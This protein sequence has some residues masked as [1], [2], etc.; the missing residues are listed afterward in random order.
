MTD[1]HSDLITEILLLIQAVDAAFETG[2]LALAED[3]DAALEVRLDDLDHQLCGLD[4]GGDVLD[5]GDEHVGIEAQFR[6]FWSSYSS[7]LGSFTWSASPSE[8][9]DHLRSV[10]RDETLTGPYSPGPFLDQAEDR[11]ILEL[12]ADLWNERQAR[13]LGTH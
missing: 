9:A 13:I 8:L 4:E 12:A 6:A 7:G 5:D 2:N 3:L 10:L 11:E 1:D